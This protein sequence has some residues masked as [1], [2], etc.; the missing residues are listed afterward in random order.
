MPQKGLFYL[1]LINAAAVVRH[2]DKGNSSVLNLYG[3][4]A[5]PGIYGVF[6]QLLH[7]A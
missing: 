5:R 1:L 2:P 7:H 3:D 6:R 4:S